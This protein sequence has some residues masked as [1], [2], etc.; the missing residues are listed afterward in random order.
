MATEIYVLI[1]YSYCDHC[2]G[3]PTVVKYGNLEELKPYITALEGSLYELIPDGLKP[4]YVYGETTEFNLKP[5]RQI[6]TPPSL[7]EY[8]INIEVTNA[9]DT[10]KRIPSKFKVFAYSDTEAEE[11]MYKQ[12]SLTYEYLIDVKERGPRF[13]QNTGD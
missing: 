6:S 3:E 4:L 1:A 5:L 12:L 2:Y 7:K 10:F 13:N 8:N 9:E 11:L